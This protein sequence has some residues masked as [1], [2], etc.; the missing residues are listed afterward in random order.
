MQCFLINKII[1]LIKRNDDFK[2]VYTVYILTNHH[3]LFPILHC[4]KSQHDLL[5]QQHLQPVE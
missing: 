5:I 4:D 2:M 1:V 3:K